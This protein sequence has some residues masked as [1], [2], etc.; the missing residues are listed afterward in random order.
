MSTIAA[1]FRSLPRTGP[2]VKLSGTGIVRTDYNHGHLHFTAPM[3]LLILDPRIQEALWFDHKGNMDPVMKA[4]YPCKNG[5]YD[6]PV[7]AYFVDF[8]HKDSLLK[9]MANEVGYTLKVY[10][11]A[12]YRLMPANPVS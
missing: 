8:C 9:H 6:A 5:K 1:A 2:R 3:G 11:D 4:S 7:V 12:G 10:D